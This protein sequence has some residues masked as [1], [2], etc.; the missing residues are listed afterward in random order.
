M[1]VSRKEATKQAILERIDVYVK[2]I[3]EE[4]EK[5]GYKWHFNLFNP[6]FVRITKGEGFTEAFSFREDIK[7]HSHYSGILEITTNDQTLSEKLT[8]VVMILDALNSAYLD[9]FD[10]TES[11]DIVRE[12]ELKLNTAIGLYFAT[13]EEEKQN[14]SSPFKQLYED[15][16]SEFNRDS[17]FKYELFQDDNTQQGVGFGQGYR[18]RVTFLVDNTR[19]GHRDTKYVFNHM[20]PDTDYIALCNRTHEFAKANGLSRDDVFGL[21]RFAYFDSAISNAFN[22]GYVT[23]SDDRC[24]LTSISHA[25]TNNAR[26]NKVIVDYFKEVIGNFGYSDPNT[27]EINTL[28]NESK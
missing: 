9:G 12:E 23:D 21:L 25:V 6:D 22:L 11:D 17:G 20:M 26:S 13:I 8:D 16:V 10:D 3:K 15:M 5:C 1:G 27:V 7:L 18:T 2:T 14:S 19:S 24:D 4:L 28:Y